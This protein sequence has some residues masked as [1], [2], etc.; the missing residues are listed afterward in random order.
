MLIDELI[1]RAFCDGYE[2]AQREFTTSIRRAKKM[3]KQGV[4]IIANARKSNPNAQFVDSL[5]PDNFIVDFARK[6]NKS[7]LRKMN[8]KRYR[9]TFPEGG[10]QL[11]KVLKSKRGLDKY[12]KKKLSTKDLETFGF[13]E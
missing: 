4:D 9:A 6:N 11:E 10:P 1:E 7:W 2:Y 13:T 12:A 3:M 5:S 8:S